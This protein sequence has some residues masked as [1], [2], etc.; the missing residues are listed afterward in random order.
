MSKDFWDKSA[1]FI[2]TAAYTVGFLCSLAILG[3]QV[4]HWLRTSIW[5]PLPMSETFSYLGIDLTRI[6]MPSDWQG[7]AKIAQW[8]L[9][10]PLAIG[11][12]AILIAAAHIWQ[13]FVSDANS[14]A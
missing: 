1:E 13:A 3:W 11:T 2:V 6:Y 5:I 7:L 12:P 14:H 9:D 8:L 4:F 10:I